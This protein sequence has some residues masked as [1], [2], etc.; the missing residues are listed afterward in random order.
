MIYLATF[1]LIIVAF[2]VAYAASLIFKWKN[3]TAYLEDKGMLVFIIS[4]SVIIIAI[5]TKDPLTV[6]GISIPTELQWLGSLIITGFGAWRFYLNPLKS[7]VYS[8]D[9]EVGEVRADVANIKS[10][11]RLIKENVISSKFKKLA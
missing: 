5:I 11:V 8:M 1:W 7:K 4:A 2:I 3:A 9:R 6:M 10:D